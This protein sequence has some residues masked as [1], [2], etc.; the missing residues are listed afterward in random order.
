MVLTSTHNLCF[1]QKYENISVFCLKIFRFLEVKFSIYLNRRVFVMLFQGALDDYDDLVFACGSGGTAAGLSI[2]NYLTGSKMRYTSL[3]I[4][5]IRKTSL[6]KFDPLKPHFYI[7]KLGFTGV[8]IVLFISAHNIDFGYS[9]EPPRRD[10]SNEYHNLCFEHQFE[11]YQTL[12]FF[13]F[14]VFGGELFYIC[15]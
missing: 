8:Y 4:F 7:V 13:I 5:T 2:A 3:L 11:K 1:E 9:L 12:S 15:E 14:S 10:G 6:H